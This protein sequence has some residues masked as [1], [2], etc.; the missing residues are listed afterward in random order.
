MIYSLMKYFCV[1]SIERNSRMVISPLG[2]INNKG[3]SGTL[4]INNWTALNAKI[5]AKT[6]GPYKSVGI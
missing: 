3:D 4:D 5:A 2:A 1:G 6:N